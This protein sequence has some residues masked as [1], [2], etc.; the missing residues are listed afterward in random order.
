MA[1]WNVGFFFI[2]LVA[3]GRMKPN[4]ALY[5]WRYTLTVYPASKGDLHPFLVVMQS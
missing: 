2:T 1:A 5:A 3:E 4:V